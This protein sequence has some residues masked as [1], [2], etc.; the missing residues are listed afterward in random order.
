MSNRAEKYLIVVAGP[1]AVGK[2]ELSIT[3]AKALNTEIISADSRQFFRELNIGTAKPDVN[4]LAEVTHH[5]INSHS[6]TENYSA[7]DFERDVLILLKRLFQDKNCVI[8]TGGSGLYIK[9]VLEGLDDLPP[10]L[11]GLRQ[12]LTQRLQAEGLTTLQSEVGR[13]DPAFAATPEIANPQRVVRALEVF[14]STG[15][16]ISNYQ[17]GESRKRAFK[18]ILIALDRDRAELYNRIEMRMDLMLDTGL[19]SEAKS[20]MN[21]RS[22]HAL[23]TVGYKEIFGFLDGL[24]DEQEMVRL[25]KQNTRRYAKR[26]LTWFRHQGDFK[27]FGADQT[28]D[29]IRYAKDSMG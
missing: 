4:E 25:L 24:Y 3:L 10:P 1:T 27:W 7:G 11:P 6:I 29:V 15:I 12:K 26:Q 5:F 2:T 17:L 20:L 21:Y 13:I 16:P 14:Y 28:E 8:M 23:Q 18:P 19:V 9:A 22:H